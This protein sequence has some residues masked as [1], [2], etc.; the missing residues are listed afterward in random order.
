M[1]HRKASEA[2]IAPRR[3]RTYGPVI[4]DPLGLV[5]EGFRITGAVFPGIG[6]AVITRNRI[7]NRWKPSFSID[8]TC[9]GEYS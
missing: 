4:N 2:T 1:V 5:R 6:Q 7:I 8:G 9:L 3:S